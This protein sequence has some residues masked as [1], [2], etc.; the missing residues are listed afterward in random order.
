VLLATH[1]RLEQLQRIVDAIESVVE[2]LP[3][4][5]Q[6]MV[7]LRYWTKSKALTWEGIANE[8]PVHR[9]TALRWRDEIVQAIADRL[10]WR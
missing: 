8:I 2:R 4:D 6:K 10:G 9:A 3:E 5:K 7:R 1:K